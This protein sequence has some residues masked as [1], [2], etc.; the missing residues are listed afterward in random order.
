MNSFYVL[1]IS[2]IGSILNNVCIGIQNGATYVSVKIHQLI[3][4]GP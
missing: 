2:N 3:V 4:I 1:L